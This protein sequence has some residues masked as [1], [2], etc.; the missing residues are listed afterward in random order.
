MLIEKWKSKRFN[1]SE[2]RYE[3]RLYFAFFNLLYSLNKTPNTFFIYYKFVLFSLFGNFSMGVAKAKPWGEL[4]V[5][6]YGLSVMGYRLSVMSYGLWV[7][8]YGL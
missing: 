3:N 1:Y 5:M 4:S 6:G 8:G 7:N 2:I